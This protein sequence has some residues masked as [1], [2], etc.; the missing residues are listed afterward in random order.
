MHRGI[1]Q[2]TAKILFGQARGRCAFP[3]CENPLIAPQTST[4]DAAV[5]GQIAHIVGA[6]DSG[7][8][9]D[10]VFPREELNKESNLLVLCPN[11]HVL[12]D[13]HDSTYTVAELRRWKRDLINSGPTAQDLIDQ[14]ALMMGD[15]QWEAAVALFEQAVGL[16]DD[17]EL[18]IREHAH[19][20]AARSL[21]ASQFGAAAAEASSLDRIEQHLDAAAEAGAGP[22]L[23]L[24]TRAWVAGLR[25][26]AESMLQHATDALVVSDATAES[27]GD[28][29]HAQ[30]DALTRLGRR[31]E[32]VQLCEGPAGVVLAELDGDPWL[33]LGVS[34][35]IV[36]AEMSSS[37]LTEATR[38]FAEQVPIQ[39]S[40]EAGT[41]MSRF[42]LAVRLSELASQLAHERCAH[43]ALEI[44]VTA[45]DV[46]AQQDDPQLTSTVALQA[47]NLAA[48][49]NDAERV[50]NALVMSEALRQLWALWPTRVQAHGIAWS[51]RSHAA[52]VSA[53]SRATR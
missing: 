27:R 1:S 3:S 41:G 15:Q 48:A 2:K 42:Q 31:D 14:A 53:S 19:M 40:A 13:A 22:S 36:L 37:Q 50:R 10:P 51:A 17:T 11:H 18:K 12:V 49:C 7:P 30:L 46:A 35:L 47:A 4:D 23:V 25:G 6:S 38:Q 32:V 44:A 28:A 8:R 20:S 34:R 21:L 52:A 5:L 29:I 24:T 39:A 26:E 16:S 33:Q 45:C 43:E 9:G